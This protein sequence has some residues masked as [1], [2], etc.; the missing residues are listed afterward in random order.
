MRRISSPR[1]HKAGRA[2]CRPRERRLPVAHAIPHRP[3]RRLV[4]G[5]LEHRASRPGAMV[6]W[7]DSCQSHRNLSIPLVRFTVPTDTSPPGTEISPW[8][9]L[10]SLHRSSAIA[11][12]MAAPR[13]RPAGPRPG[14]GATTVAGSRPLRRRPTRTR[15]WCR[16]S[17]GAVPGAPCLRRQDARRS[18]QAAP[19]A[20]AT[21]Q[22]PV[23]AV[24]LAGLGSTRGVPLAPAGRYLVS[25][26]DGTWRCHGRG[27]RR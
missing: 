25:R 24:V 8:G 2:P 26:G 3:G 17:R 1:R 22:V 6:V 4:T 9:P 10:K 7:Q 23:G 21:V 11:P 16:R 5:Q 14:H 12:G 13:A 18:R 20:T 15:S 19:H 27:Q